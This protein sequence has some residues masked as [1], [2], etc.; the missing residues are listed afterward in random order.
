MPPRELWRIPVGAGWSGFAVSGGIA[1]TQEQRGESE[2]VVAAG[3]PRDVSKVAR[4]F[5]GQYLKECLRVR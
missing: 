3:T 5:T 1:V 2:Q 4:S